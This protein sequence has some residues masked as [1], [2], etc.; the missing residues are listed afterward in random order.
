MSTSQLQL[1]GLRDQLRAKYEAK[2]IDVV[3]AAM[4]PS[5]DFLLDHGDVVFPGT[6]IVFCGIDRRE[7]GAR[8][9]P[10]RV[11]GVL[12]RRE[13]KPTLE[14][15]P[16]VFLAFDLLEEG[17]ADLRARPLALRR[18]RLETVVQGLGPRL[19]GRVLSVPVGDHFR[20]LTLG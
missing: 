13:F 14:Q 8:V 17:G 10:A 2:N 19:G 1:P 11:T 3:I 20:A 16:V 4:G 5:L 15:A 6:P 7:L 12:V 18:E 9:L